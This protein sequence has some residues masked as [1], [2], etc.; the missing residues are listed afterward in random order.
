MIEDVVDEIAAVLKASAELEGGL[1]HAIREGLATFWS[2]LVADQANLQVI[3]Y[4]LVTYALR[5]PG[6]ESLARWQYDRYASIVAEWCQE[7]AEQ[8]RRDLCAVPFARLARVLVAA[9][10]RR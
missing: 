8:R 7:A 3:Q 1:E 9:R 6:M 4:E 2:Q 5:T 10:R